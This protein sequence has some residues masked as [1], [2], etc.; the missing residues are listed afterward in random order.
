MKVAIVHYW[1]LNMRGG[2]KV[3]EAL[4]EMFPDADLFTHIY[5]PEAI[6]PTIRRHKVQTSFIA[7]LPQARRRYQSYLPLMPRALEE[8]DLRAYD[9]V[10]SSESGP[11]KGVITRPDAVHVCYCHTP[12]RYL[13]NM[14]HDYREEA[15]PLKR[16][17]I[18]FFAHRLRQWDVASAARVDHFVANSQNVAR[19]VW[20]FYRRDAAVIYPPVD[21][22]FYR[23]APGEPDEF[24]LYVGQLTRYKRVDIAIEAFNRL[25]KPLIVIGDGEE[26]NAL[27]RLA[28]PTIRF[29]GR[30]E[31]AVLRDHYARCRALI[32]PGEEDF[33]IVPVEVMASGR[34]V[35]AFGRGGARET[36]VPGRTGILF[37][38]QTP[39]ALI[40]AI[41]RFEKF[42]AAFD[43]ATIAAHASNFSKDLFQRNFRK[44]VDDALASAAAP[45]PPA[46]EAGFGAA[47]RNDA[48]RPRLA[49]A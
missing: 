5:N 24:Y 17:A 23:P 26:R 19:R 38:E 45:P 39:E 42:A 37:D 35:L 6:S 11:A 44:F 43:P 22:A 29:L 28:G 9:L 30:A 33:G 41:E 46:V 40:A 49:Q 4:C 8:L 31:D 47:H 15:G 16:L 18:S 2:E 13:W 34:P 7:R 36:V 14:Y 27:T 1:L 12:M 3:V 25:G 32:F 10:I 20:K 21:T 48:W